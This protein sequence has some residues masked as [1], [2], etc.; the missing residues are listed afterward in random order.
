MPEQV[1]IRISY[2]PAIVSSLK[3]QPSDLETFLSYLHSSV[4]HH[5]HLLNQNF[6]SIIIICCTLI[7]PHTQCDAS[8]QWTV[9]A[10]QAT[11][12][13][14]AAPPPQSSDKEQKPTVIVDIFY[15]VNPGCL[16]DLEGK[17]K[18]AIQNHIVGE[19][20]ARLCTM[21][22]VLTQLGQT[23]LTVLYLSEIG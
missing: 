12:F 8:L 14:K 21:D 19:P 17:L 9:T 3:V 13:C 18:T 7:L 22:I 2:D 1:H 16:K 11:V 20:S 23:M 5:V 6:T 10:Q 15:N 4:S